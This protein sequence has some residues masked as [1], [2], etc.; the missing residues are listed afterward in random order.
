[1]VVVQFV[2]TFNI[3]KFYLNKKSQLLF[4]LFYFFIFISEPTTQPPVVT[5]AATTDTRTTLEPTTPSTPDNGGLDNGRSSDSEPFFL[6][7]L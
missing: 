1:M 7:L 3:W 4:I 5:T 6:P 2:V